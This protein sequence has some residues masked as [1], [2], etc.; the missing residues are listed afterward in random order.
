MT[1]TFALPDL[2]E[3]L[4]EAE[5]VRW[6]VKVGDE[7]ALNQIIAEVETAK[8]LVELPSPH[9][10]VVTSL[11][12]DEG[13]TIA[14]GCPIIVFAT[15]GEAVGAGADHPGDRSNPADGMDS[16]GSGHLAERAVP[17]ERTN[18]AGPAAPAGPAEADP[19]DGRASVLVGYGP[20]DHDPRSGRRRSRR[21][22]EA[23]ASSAA[24]PT[25][26][27]PAA[28]PPTPER[29]A[30]APPV[31][32]LA[33]SLGIDLASVPASAPDGRL[34]RADVERAALAATPAHARP[35]G[36]APADCGT[37]GG[38]RPAT[39]D[40]DRETSRGHIGGSVRD[41][42][43]GRSGSASDE[44]RVRVSG[45]R[46]HTAAAMVRS[47]FTAPHVTEFV[48]IDVT[49]TVELV[50][51]LREHPLFD[52]VRVTPLLLV[53]RAVVVALAGHPE[54][55]SSWDEEAQEIV[56]KH[57]VH[58]GI[59]A[60]TPRGLMVPNIRDTAG[61]SL[62]D[63]AVAIAELTARAKDGAS[64]PAEL[65]G[66]TFTITNIGSFGIDA[67]TP[68]INPG[69]AGILCVGAIREQPWVVDHEIVIRQVL[70]LSLSFDHR[71][72]DGAEGS[73]FLASVARMISDPIELAIRA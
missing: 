72:V 71:L 21:A 60:A 48:T 20:G 26:E 31:R 5:L 3:G 44:T 9:V 11:E 45:V 25:P 7:V 32:R 30:A 49:P 34:R 58:L 23:P 42:S 35:G 46:K 59:A 4:S 65:I 12:F 64:T 22:A 50:A 1:L 52:G 24:P 51:R 53:A 18:P 33:R 41:A 28:V 36:D 66:G 43:D 61:Y 68:I 37:F 29:P 8:A 40:E 15:A 63:L 54:L 73:A 2:G 70:T 19:D 69:E 57:R 62:R 38:T 39:T 47:A 17:A 27:R 10:G 6:M 14:V 55:N 56:T 16:A 13:A 67:G